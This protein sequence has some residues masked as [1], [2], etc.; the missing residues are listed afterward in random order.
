[1]YVY[2]IQHLSTLTRPVLKITDRTIMKHIRVHLS[3]WLELHALVDLKKRGR[4]FKY[5]KHHMNN[6]KQNVCIDY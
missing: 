4:S 5:S 3:I 2:Q 6:L 1:M